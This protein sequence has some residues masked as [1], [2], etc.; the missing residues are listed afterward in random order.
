MKVLS[1][2]SQKGGVGKT[3]LATALAVAAESDGKKVAVFDLDDQASACFW[4]DIREAPTP[5]VSDVKA[6]RLP[7]YL[8]S[9]RE[10]GCDLVIIDCPPVHKDIALDAASPAD[11]VL[12][13]SKPDLFDIRSMQITVDL[14]SKIDKQ[15][16]VVLTFCP[17]A[18]PEVPSARDA[19]NQIGAV[20]CPV[21][22]GLRKSYA[23][24]QQ[25]GRAAQEFEPD[26]KAAEE[27]QKLYEYMCIHLYTVFKFA[28]LSGVGC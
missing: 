24:A 18:G 12:I 21:E 5:A 9:M 10:A 3:T 28:I 15:C 7:A 14:L 26:G 19:V 23:R 17:P 1:I 27:I 8:D 2:I 11:F 22:I 16:A 25:S 4:S 13:P 6:V 20:L